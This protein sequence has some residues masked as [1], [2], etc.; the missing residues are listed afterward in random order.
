MESVYERYGDHIFWDHIMDEFYIKNLNDP[1]LREFYVGKDLQRIKRMNQELLATA[2]RS[3]ANHFLVS[4]KRT[5]RS[6]EIFGVHFEKFVSNL[7]LT[8]AENNIS[9]SDIQEIIAVIE[10]FRSDLVKD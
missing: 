5:H 6:M 9:K 3:S 2:L 10:S 7:G 1:G 4:V 8:L